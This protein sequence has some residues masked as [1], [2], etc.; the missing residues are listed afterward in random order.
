MKSS[1]AVGIGTGEDA[2][3]AGQKAAQEALNGLNGEDPAVYFVFSTPKYDLDQML[4]GVRSTHAQAIIVGATTSGEIVRGEHIAAGQGVS[5]LALTKG[6]YEFGIASAE[7][8]SGRL[9]EVGQSLTREAY[10]MVGKTPYSA[11]LIFA[12]CLAGDLQQL[13]RGA[14]RTTGPKT[15]LVGGAASDEMQFK[16]TYVFHNEKVITCGAVALWI[17]GNEPF[18]VMTCH[19]WEPIGNPLLVTRADGVNIR[20]LDGRPAAEVYKEQLGFKPGEL[21]N[22]NF[23][24]NAVHHPLGLM[25]S[26]E[27]FIIRAARAQSEDGGLIIQGCVPEVGSAI[28]IMSSTNEKLL[29]VT[30][31]IGSIVRARPHTAALLVFSCAARAML[32]GPQTKDEAARLQKAVGDVSVNGFHCC[33]E[34]A[35]T[36]GVLGTHNL[37]MTALAL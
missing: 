36:S 29:A 8:I 2:Y 33:G 4:E 10:D 28:Q 16:Q 24:K 6:E 7:N 30:E 18:D 20:E 5:V 32:L 31:E 13:F 17:G 23:W 15:P 9:D 14:Y 25:Q 19:G 35:R 21:T 26:N 3:R 27:S 12:D 11:V 22:E 1:A 34:F 37:T